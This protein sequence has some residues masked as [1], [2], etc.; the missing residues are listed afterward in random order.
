MRTKKHTQL[1]IRAKPTMQ[2][3][4]QA[5]LLRK[6]RLR[7]AMHMKKHTQRRIWAKPTMQQTRQAALLRKKKE[8]E[9][10]GAEGGTTKGEAKEAATAAR[11][12]A[13]M[14]LKTRAR[15]RLLAQQTPAQGW[16]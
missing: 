1:R 5:A 4:R 11:Q 3:T 13:G 15:L 6:A 16:R 8:A 12:L 9:A 2:Q 14:A 7:K 10:R